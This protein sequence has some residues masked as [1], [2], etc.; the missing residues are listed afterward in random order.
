MCDA[1]LARPYEADH[2]AEVVKLVFKNRVVFHDGEDEI[3]PG[4]S[5]HLIGGHSAGLQA[6]RVHTQRGWVALA[7]DSAHYYENIEKRR[8][9]PVVYHVGQ[10]VEGYNKLNRLADSPKHIVPGHDP[11]VLK[12]YPAPRDDLQ[13]AV[14]RLDVD[15]IA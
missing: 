5:V 15:P 2:V 7:S 13:G 6:V 10:M 14:A 4:I 11:L 3:A 1:G 9:F 8:C 12:R